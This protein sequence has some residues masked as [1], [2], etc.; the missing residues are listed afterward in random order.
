MTPPNRH[1]LVIAADHAELS[2]LRELI[3]NTQYRVTMA[4]DAPGAVRALNRRC[5]H[6]IVMSPRIG[7]TDPSTLITSIQRRQPEAII[8]MA[9]SDL[10][11]P[12]GLAPYYAAGLHRFLVLPSDPAT[13][14]YEI[15]KIRG[16]LNGRRRREREESGL[17]KLWKQLRRAD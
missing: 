6:V 12:M 15:V 10:Y 4:G 8:V 13:F 5:F 3:P 7:K 14:L 1:A 11:P 2:E 17:I 16:E 9:S